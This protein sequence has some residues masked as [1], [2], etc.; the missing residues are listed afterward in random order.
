[1]AQPNNNGP[2]IHPARFAVNLNNEQEA[3]PQ[4][5]ANPPPAPPAPQPPNPP[6]P[7]QPA[8]GYQQAPPPAA[9]QPQN[10]NEQ[11]LR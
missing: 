10:A 7:A 9:Q 4:Q 1:M 11:Q 6:P 5:P 8:N 2:I 3:A